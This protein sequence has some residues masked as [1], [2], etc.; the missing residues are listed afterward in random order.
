MG[1]TIARK[2]WNTEK[3]IPHFP[4]EFYE[5]FLSV[6]GVRFEVIF[7]PSGCYFSRKFRSS[8]SIGIR[9]WGFALVQMART[10]GD[11]RPTNDEEHSVQ[12]F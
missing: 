11:G 5:T 10:N 6:L 1:I 3:I 7:S 12:A 9:A 4:C 8:S 2:C